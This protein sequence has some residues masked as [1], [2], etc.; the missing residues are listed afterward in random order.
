M[1]KDLKIFVRHLR[2]EALA[3][4][5]LMAALLY[6]SDASMWWL[7]IGFPFVDLCMVGYAFGPK[8]G[9]LTY[10]LAHNATIPTL[11]IA[12]GVI[13]EIEVLSVIGFVWTFH[14]AIDRLLGYGLKHNHSFKE[15]HLGKIGK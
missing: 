9:A 13:F 5:I 10:N 7:L 4:A 1:Q 11:L 15:T 3:L 14:T 6:R 8:T 12:V 2:F